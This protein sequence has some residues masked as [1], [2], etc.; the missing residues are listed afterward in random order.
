MNHIWKYWWCRNNTKLFD[1]SKCHLPELNVIKMTKIHVIVEYYSVIYFHKT[2]RWTGPYFTSPSCIDWSIEACNLETSQFRIYLEKYHSTK[3]VFQACSNY[4]LFAH[5]L[6][7]WNNVGFSRINR[8]DDEWNYRNNI[9]KWQ[10]LVLYFK[11][12]LFI[13]CMQ[14]NDMIEFI[15]ISEYIFRSF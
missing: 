2:S 10:L 15:L 9:Y 4:S 12:Y 11:A 1:N 13:I 8:Q 5:H 6:R 3:R 7:E 14:D